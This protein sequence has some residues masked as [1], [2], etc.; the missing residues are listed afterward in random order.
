MQ[1][2][3]ILIKNI[4]Q[5]L[6]VK[7]NQELLKGAQMS[8]LPML[9]NAWLA[10]EDDRIIAYGSMEDFPGIT[11]WKG[12]HVFD[13]EGKVVC[14]SWIDSHTHIVY[15][16]TRQGEF[17]DRIKGLSYEDIAAK[18]GGILNSALRL[19]ET[20]EE[21]L[22]D[23]ASKRLTALLSMGTGAIEIK[24][25]YGLDKESELKM[26]RV[27]HRLKSNFP[28][29]IKANL[30]AAHAVPPEFKGDP[31]GYIDHIVSDILPE[32][33]EQGLIDYVDIFCERGY[34]D[35]RHTTRLLDAASNLGVRA[36][37]HVNQFSSS[38]GVKV[39][40][41]HNALSVDHLEVL[42][43]SDI[44]ALKNSSTIPVALPGCSLFISIP[45]TPARKIIDSGLPL[46]LASDYNPGSTPSG[47]MNLVNSLASIKMNMTPAEVINASTLNAAYALEL[48]K[49][50]GSISIGKKANLFITEKIPDYSFL[51]YSYGENHIEE[52]ILNGE[53]LKRDEQATN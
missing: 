40:V 9:E 33:H 30:L 11:N 16:G 3:N 41:D 26:L 4:K 36:K 7:E 25:G 52:I 12:L 8:E 53:I 31:D 51:M 34:F 22:Y 17:V 20:S 28:I 15:A 45:Y 37:I 46:V 50:Y 49:D 10:I 44:E 43:D 21:E 27:I 1:I 24:S 29:P 32:A 18:G 38:G 13:A 42:E 5:L 23:Q 35:T 2:V 14:P 19:R 47:N 39:A 6:Q 48:E